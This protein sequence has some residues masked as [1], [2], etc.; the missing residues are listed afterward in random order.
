MIIHRMLKLTVM[1]D[2]HSLCLSE[3]LRFYQ[4]GSSRENLNRLADI[5]LLDIW[6]REF[7]LLN[8]VENIILLDIIQQR[9]F[10]T[11]Y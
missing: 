1:E 6:Q 3:Y 9:E 8:I 4:S 5:I 11:F 2:T 7:F 10:L